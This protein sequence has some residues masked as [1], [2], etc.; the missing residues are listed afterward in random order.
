MADLLADGAVQAGIATVYPGHIL[1]LLMRTA[2]GGDDLF[3]VQFGAVDQ[4]L[5][6]VP[7]EHG[8]RHQRTGIDDHR[9]LADQPL[10]LDCDQFRVAGAGA[11]EVD[12]HGKSLQERGETFNRPG[13]G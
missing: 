9:A 10:A 2:H 12:R 13:R 8:R 6:L 3:Q 4:G 7:L 1:A 5:G 11:D